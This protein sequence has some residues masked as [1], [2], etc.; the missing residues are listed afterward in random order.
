MSPGEGSLF[1]GLLGRDGFQ[2]LGHLYLAFRLCQAV[3]ADSPFSSACG[4]LRW[5]L[6]WSF[7][8]THMVVQARHT[9]QVGNSRRVKKTP[10]LQ[11]L[12]LDEAGP[13]PTPP[14]SSVQGGLQ[15][16][17]AGGLDSGLFFWLK[18]MSSCWVWK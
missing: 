17:K 13:Y 5:P 8:G 7:K 4:D 9:C 18:D 2:R 10:Q 12:H 1:P 15:R 16:A 3:E 11:V 6:C 14:R